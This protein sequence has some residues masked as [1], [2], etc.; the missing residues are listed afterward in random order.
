MPRF[1]ES[2]AVIAAAGN[3]PKKISEY[4]GRVKTGEAALSIARMISPPGWIEPGQTPDFAEYSLVLQG[5]L[6]VES[7]DGTVEVGAGRA[8]ALSPGEWVRY[9]TPRGAEYLSVCVPAFTPESAHR[10]P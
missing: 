3:P 4:I 5:V 8:I 10:D 6:R 9:S 2:A 1:I 7:R